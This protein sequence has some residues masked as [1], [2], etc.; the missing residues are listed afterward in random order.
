MYQTGDRAARM[1][2]GTLSFLG[3]SDRQVKIRGNRVELGQVE[4]ALHQLDG[5]KDAVAV[6]VDNPPTGSSL[7]AYVEARPEMTEAD[8]RTGLLDRLPESMLPTAIV[9]MAKIPRSPLNGKVARAA[10]PPVGKARVAAAD[11]ATMTTLERAVAML[12]A[13]V[14]GTP[15]GDRHENFFA[16]G[17]DSLRGMQILSR[18]AEVTGVA[19]TFEQFRAAPHVAGIAE[20]VLRLRGAGIGAQAIVPLASRDEWQPASRGQQALWYLDQ[21]HRGAPLYAIPVAYRIQGPLDLERLDAALSTIV[22]RHDALRSVLVRKG[23]AVWQHTLPAEPVRT[24]VVRVAGFTDAADRAQAA[25]GLPFDLAKGP[26]LRSTAFQLDDE[27]LWLLDVHHA[28]FDAWSLA[29]FWRELTALYQGKPLPDVAVQ[30]ADYAAWQQSWLAGPEADAQRKYWSAQLTDAPAPAPLAPGR[31]GRVGTAGFALQLPPAAIDT[32]AV[33]RVARECR[34]TPFTVLL[35]SFF[36]ALGR[37]VG[38][39]EPVVG[40]PVAC[41]NRPGT[42]NVIGY[43]VNTVV[44]RAKLDPDSSFRKVVA[45]VDAAMAEAL[46]NQELPFADA[47]EGASRGARAGDNPI[48]Q[49]M[50]G[51][52]STPLD[53]LDG[54]EGLTIAEHFVHSGTAKT[55]LT[56]TARHESTGL[57]GE[58]EYAADAFDTES[59][60]QWRTDLLSTLNAALTSPDEPIGELAEGRVI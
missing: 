42:E 3:R 10:L 27:W 18:V 28:A 25:A 14:V 26:L 5:V 47:T 35:A 49:A 32:A 19:L 50:F 33:E 13:D 24:E 46:T 40:L 55:A 38:T 31:S 36:L 58:I 20:T 15:V 59:A 1:P 52:Q 9:L 54:I 2:D 48:F 37:A 29:V 6:V 45:D 4:S 22:A 11:D 21:V 30:Y 60:T 39:D 43:L 12:V 57:V 53:G 41:R 17:G 56:W 34:S 23:G 16:I 8:I 44:L 7:V 51:F